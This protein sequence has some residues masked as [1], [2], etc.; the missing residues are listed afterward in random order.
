[1]NGGRSRLDGGGCR[2][3]EEGQNARWQTERQVGMSNGCT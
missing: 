3:T 1:M 2:R